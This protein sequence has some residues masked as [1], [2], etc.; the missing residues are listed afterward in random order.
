MNVPEINQLIRE[1]LYDGVKDQP[2]R[3]FIEEV[4]NIERDYP[5]QRGKIK[6]YEE[7]LSKYVRRD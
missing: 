5:V 6:K 3:D 4:M 1:K 7:T 2:M